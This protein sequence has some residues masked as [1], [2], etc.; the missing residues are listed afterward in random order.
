MEGTNGDAIVTS[1]EKERNTDDQNDEIDSAKDSSSGEQNEANEKTGDTNESEANKESENEQP[2]S[3]GISVFDKL[4]KIYI[5][6]WYL[7]LKIIIYHIFPK[8]Q[9][10]SIHW[11]GQI[12]VF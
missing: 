1:D 9:M 12:S 4:V 7:S 11:T 2:E 8:C 10:D 3:I 6:R 5:F